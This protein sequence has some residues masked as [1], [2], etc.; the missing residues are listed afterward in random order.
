MKV[1][2]FLTLGSISIFIG[3]YTAYWFIASSS[4]EKR[5]IKWADTQKK[6]GLIFDVNVSEV[7]GYPLKFEVIFQKPKIKNLT[8]RW[9]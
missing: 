1:I 6:R 3:A 4:I 8:D 5:I 9:S 7:R 2:F